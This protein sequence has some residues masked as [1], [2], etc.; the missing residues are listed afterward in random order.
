MTNN[1]IYYPFTLTEYEG[2]NSLLLTETKWDTFEKN[3]FLGNGYDWNRLIENL[4]KEKLPNILETLVF[5]SE[6]DMFCVRSHDKKSLKEIANLV[7]L[8]Y[9]DEN[10]L[11]EKF[12]NTLNIVHKP[13]P[14]NILLASNLLN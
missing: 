13:N 2:I 9:D 4:L 14:R 1:N 5:D 8:F 3:G 7:S 10:Q 11:T 6:A 12:L